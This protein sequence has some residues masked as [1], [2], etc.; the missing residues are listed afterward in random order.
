L[1]CNDQLGGRRIELACSG[2][3][4]L[5]PHE[6]I[7][8]EVLFEEPLVVAASLENPWTRCRK[9]DLADLLD[10]SW[11]WS[12]PGTVNHGLIVEAFRACGL[13]RAYVGTGTLRWRAG[14]AVGGVGSGS[15][16]LKKYPKISC[17]NKI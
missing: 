7:D 16:L 1:R 6:D 2:S 4:S 8:A 14:S 9:V 17:G 10:A 12:P 11:T 3:S 15:I 5:D 13:D